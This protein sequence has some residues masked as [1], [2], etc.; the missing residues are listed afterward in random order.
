MEIPSNGNTELVQERYPEESV[1]A[2]THCF[3]RKDETP[4]ALSPNAVQ[5]GLGVFRFQ[6]HF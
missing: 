4:D 6:T 1:L 5:S 3:D 2:A